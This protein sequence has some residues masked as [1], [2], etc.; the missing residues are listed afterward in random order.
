MSRAG[1]VSRRVPVTQSPGAPV[2]V[3][4]RVPVRQSPGAP[5]DS[6]VALNQQPRADQDHRDGVPT[7]QRES[8]PG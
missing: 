3:S 1:G 5:R 8:P 4:G 7:E 6:G 2:A